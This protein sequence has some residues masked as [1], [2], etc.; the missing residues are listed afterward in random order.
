MSSVMSYGLEYTDD[1]NL[2]SYSDIIDV[3]SPAEYQE[4]HIPG[5]LNL[6][7]LDDGER[8]HVGTLYKQVDAF[9]AKRA[10]AALVTKN[11]AA[12]LAT[13]LAD[14]P[15]DYRP[16]IYCW[17]G[18]MRS[19]SLAIICR[20]IGWQ[21]SLLEGGY[22]RYR[23]WVREI[24]ET[25]CASFSLIRIA[26]PTGCGKTQL[27]HLL[28]ERGCQV[29][30]LEGLAQHKGSAL[31]DLPGIP[32]PSQKY[33]ETQIAH[34]IQSFAANRPI[35]LESESS[36]VGNL[37]CPSLLWEKMKQ[38][39]VVQ[40]S[41]PREQRVALLLRQY[42]YFLRDPE[43]L[44]QALQALQKRHGRKTLQHWYG[45]IDQQQWSLLVDSLLEAHYDIVYGGTLAAYSE[46]SSEHYPLDD[47]SHEGLS[48]IADR[49][50]ADESELANSP[51]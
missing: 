29:L 42:D 13:E 4:D 50:S 45:L 49:L 8:A 19:R 16:L 31:G 23:A 40:I 46:P 18:G 28:R 2:K 5:A 27:L 37:H 51:V 11:I 36:R 10:G 14:K 30:D 3:R 43:S 39:R 26:G 24:L 15:R 6:P 20:Q 7:V 32:Q 34:T 1:F 35:W 12:I 17:R 21:T 38:A 47:L 33:F 25:R 41:A 22:K 44:K 48:L 9:T